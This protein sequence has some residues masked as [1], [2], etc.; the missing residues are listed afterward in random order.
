MIFKHLKGQRLY[1]SELI[2][3]VLRFFFLS[4]TG[5]GPHMVDWHLPVTD[6][7]TPQ[8]GRCTPVQGGLQVKRNY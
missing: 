1:S 4:L 3:M 5:R 8:I 2:L 7:D 6:C